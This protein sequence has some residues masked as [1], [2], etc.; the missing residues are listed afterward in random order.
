VVRAGNFK[1][2]SKTGSFFDIPLPVGAQAKG[3][4]KGTG[5][6]EDEGEDGDEE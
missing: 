5:S 6:V 1:P 2:I 4:Y 3:R